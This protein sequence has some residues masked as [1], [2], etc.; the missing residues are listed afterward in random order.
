[1]S[2]P[3]AHL[4]WAQVVARNIV[5]LAGIVFLGWNAQNVLLVYFA[6]TVLTL[7]VLFAGVLHKFA[8]PVVD[9][10]WAA[11]LNGE[12][13]LI[14]GGA[15]LAACFAV[16]LGIPVIFML[17]GRF[18]LGAMIADPSLQA[19]LAWQAVAALWSYVG[20]WRAL[21]HA[22]P[23]ELRL[24]GRFSLTFLRWLALVIVAYM[25]VGFVFG[26]HSALAFVAIYIA[27]S[28]WAEVAPNRFLRAM[29]GGA[30]DADPLPGTDVPSA[31]HDT[32]QRPRRRRTRRQ[33]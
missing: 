21:R 22:T 18:D 27:I 6:D 14:A 29:P 7:G 2:A 11:R 20:L 32:Q 26:R 4:A 8:P 23:D 17:G 28:I 15:F 1:M 10:G 24:K 33:A 3:A 12:A 31:M 5:P 19:G 30:E 9:D 16:P 13:G 25:G